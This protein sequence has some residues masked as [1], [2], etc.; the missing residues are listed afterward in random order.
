VSTRSLEIKVGVAVTLASV[1]LIV[2]IMWLQRFKL[3]E[4]RYHFYVTFPDVGGLTKDDP[5]LIN[6]VEKGKVA[7]VFLHEHGVVVEMGVREKVVFPRDSRISLRSIGIMGERFVAIQGGASREVVA[8]G[9]TLAGYL[10]SGMSEVMGETG[11]VLEELVASTAHLKEVLR[12]ILEDG[13]LSESMSNFHSVSVGLKDV[14]G[15]ERAPLYVAIRRFDHVTTMLD[16][17]IG[18]RYASLDS[19]LQSFS[20]AGKRMNAAVDNLNA[21]AADLKELTER[22]NA[23]QGTLGKLIREDSLMQDVNATM[24]NLNDLID[25]IKKHPGRYLSFR[26]F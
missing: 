11:R 13:H 1:I 7:G 14:A 10:E 26:L 12:V 19:T 16:S 5:I 25:D 2:G 6:G 21:V 22:V 9:D 20:S 18:S 23:G 24:K 4:K 3:V 17:L 15:D 8:P